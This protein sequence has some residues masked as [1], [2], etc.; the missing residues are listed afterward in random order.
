MRFVL[1]LVF[2][3][4]SANFAQASENAQINKKINATYTQFIEAFDKLNADLVKP[5]YNPDAIY[6]PE[7]KSDN[8]FFGSNE[9]DL[10]YQRFFNR[11]K[12]KNAK[13]K[14]G[15]RIINRDITKDRVTDIGYYLIRFMPADHTEQPIS[16]FSGKFLIISRP[17]S[18][19]KWEWAT[20][21]NNKAKS[22]FY[23]DAKPQ[24]G[25]FYS[26]SQPLTRIKK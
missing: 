6:V 9:I 4:I 5:I 8:L 3:Y 24:N 26:E 10:I 15:F 19:G 13:V 1:I 25:L 2:F 20:E 21:M 12:H 7:H 23:F 17:T 22:E 18:S 11:V 16:E 14:V